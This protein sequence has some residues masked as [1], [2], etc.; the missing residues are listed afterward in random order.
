MSAL[1]IRDK[2]AVLTLL[3]SIGGAIAGYSWNWN[4]KTIDWLRPSDPSA[5][6]SGEAGAL[7]CFPLVPY[8]NRIR[9]GRFMFDGEQVQLPVSTQDPHFEH[10]H[11]WRG[12][13]SIE[14]TGPG[15]ALLRF[16]HE[17]DG[18]PWRYEAHQLFS[19]DD[20]VLAI[21]LRLRNISDRTMPAGLGLHPYFPLASG[22]YVEAELD[23][24][25]ETDSEVLPLCFRALPPGVQR[26]EAGETSLD[27]VFTG[28]PHRATITWPKEGRSLVM[29]ASSPLDFL[30]LYTPAGES[31]FC[32]E[33]VSNATDAFNMTADAMARSGMIALQPGEESTASVRLAPILTDSPNQ[34]S[35]QLGN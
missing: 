24:V 32:C 1:I 29:E 11:G 23:G 26:I 8:S 3:P 22:A 17:P 5:L 21:E 18:W 2:L 20:G 34:A 35:A 31:F 7:S 15:R 13:W 33:P 25:W 10:G 6:E 28:W 4:G 27:N 9:Q 12:S 30:V 16:L 14:S 19:L